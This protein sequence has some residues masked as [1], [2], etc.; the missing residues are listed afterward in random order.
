MKK[1]L[2]LVVAILLMLSSFA[3]VLGQGVQA[4]AQT[5]DEADEYFTEFVLSDSTFEGE[6][7]FSHSF[8]YL[9]V[10]VC[11]KSN[12]VNIAKRPHRCYN[13]ITN[14][15]NNKALSKKNVQ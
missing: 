15:G 14:I 5:L 2:G 3:T 6:L 10:C 1:L 7:N 4:Y 13:S 11:Y 8:C 12:G 9:S